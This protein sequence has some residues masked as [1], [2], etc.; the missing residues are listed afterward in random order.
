VAAAVLGAGRDVAYTGSTYEAQL[1]SSVQQLAGGGQVLAGRT[2]VAELTAAVAVAGAVITNDTGVAHLA[3]ACRTPSVVLFGPEPPSRWGPP[4]NGPH[5]AL[6]HGGTGDPHGTELDPTLAA[7]TVDEVLAA[8]AEI[9]PA[10]T[11]P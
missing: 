8:L 6:W 5:R 9:M 3:T 1:C 10:G 11:R 7:I 4:P 2:D